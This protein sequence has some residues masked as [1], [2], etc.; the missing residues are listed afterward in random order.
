MK[1][2]DSEVHYITK[3]DNNDAND[4]S[5]IPARNVVGLYADFTI[6]YLGYFLTFAKSKTGIAILLIIPGVYL[7]VSQML[8]LWRAIRESEKSSK[9]EKPV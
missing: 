8:S 1:T 6:P 4:P 9:A 5:P 3:G 2:V 7:I